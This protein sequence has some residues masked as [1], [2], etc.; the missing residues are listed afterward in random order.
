[1]CK[2]LED[3][4]FQVFTSF[5]VQKMVMFCILVCCVCSDISEN[6]FA[7]SF[8][9]VDLITLDAEV[10]AEENCISCIARCQGIGPVMAVK[11]ERGIVITK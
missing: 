3:I 8:G 5:D 11:G 2:I 1:V 7:S 10:V 9:L 4:S 6:H